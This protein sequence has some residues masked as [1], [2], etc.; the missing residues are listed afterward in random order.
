[1]PKLPR[2]VLAFNRASANLAAGGLPHEG[3]SE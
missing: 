1:M 3:F 2:E